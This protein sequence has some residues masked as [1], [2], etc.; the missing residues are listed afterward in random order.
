LKETKSANDDEKSYNKLFTLY[1]IFFFSFW[2][3]NC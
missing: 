1:F 3:R 2:F